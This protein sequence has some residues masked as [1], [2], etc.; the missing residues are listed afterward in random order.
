MPATGHADDGLRLPPPRVLGGAGGSARVGHRQHRQPD[1]RGRVDPDDPRRTRR[2][3]Q[4]DRH[5]EFVCRRRG[6]TSHR[7]GIA[8]IRPARR[9]VHRHQGVLPPGT[10]TQRS[11]RVARPLD[12]GVRRL[13]AS[14]RHRP[15][16]P[17]PA[18]SPR[19]HGADRRD[20]GGVERPGPRRQGPLHRFVDRARV[21]SARRSDDRRSQ[22]SGAL[23][24]RATPIQ[25]ARS[26]GRERTRPNGLD[27]RARPTAVV[28]A[29]DG[30][31]WRALPRRRHSSDRVTRQR[32]AAASMPSGC[33]GPR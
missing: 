26:P 14:P 31:P 24:H 12:A 5:L 17:L 7:A 4:S 21:A 1:A 30:H 27:P 22:G 11:G 3:H 20:N 19:L 16:R 29:G 33:L 13:V 18:P 6:R 2:W 8:R 25:P 9:G 32:N 10:W 15:H 28:A 23:R